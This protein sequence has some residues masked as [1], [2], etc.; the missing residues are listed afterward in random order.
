MNIDPM[1][2]VESKCTLETDRAG[3]VDKIVQELTGRS[4]ADVRGLFDHDCVTLN[5]QPCAEAGTVV[6]AGDVVAV[7][8]DPHRRYR[9]KPRAHESAVYRLVYEDDD[10]IV[11]D[12]AA[13]VLTV[14]TRKGE[15]HT[16]LGAVSLYLSRRHHRG[17][18]H[19]VHR[20]DRGTSGLLVFGKSARVAGQLQNQFRG[21]KP[22]REYAAIV[23]GVVERDEGT[24]DTRLGTTKSLQR[25]SV[26]EDEEGESAI[27]HYRVECRLKDA[28]F[29]RVR[30]ETGRR[31]QIRVHF[32]EAGHPVLG[33][34]RY[35]A[36]LARHRRWTA[37]RLALH[38]TTL[39][40]EHPRT[41]ETLR[42]QSPLPPEFERFLNTQRG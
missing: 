9:E 6:K 42:F 32:A 13:R 5:G 26:R 4:R 3:R 20:L 1:P 24:F 41:G 16:L 37:R 29:L 10:L 30:L 23:A 31:N 18:A 15:T 22:E 17:Q 7:R 40:F 34:D 14:P 38:A 19:V 35:R 11:V 25:Y 8:H 39:G 28:T 36:E 2:I 33:D 21:R 27:T 12:K